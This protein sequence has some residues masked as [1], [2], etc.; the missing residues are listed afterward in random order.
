MYLILFFFF[1]YKLKE[2]HRHGEAGSVDLKAVEKERE[3]VSKVLDKYAIQDRWNTDE[4][5]LFGL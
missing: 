4:A 2:Y 1:R 5:G 3:R